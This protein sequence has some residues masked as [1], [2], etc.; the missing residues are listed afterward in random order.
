MREGLLCVCVYVCVCMY[1]CVCVC[2][3]VSVF[4]HVCA[5]V[6]RQSI[7]TYFQVPVDNVVLVKEPDGQGD[8]GAV[9]ARPLLPE[10][11]CLG[12][13]V[14]QLPSGDVLHHKA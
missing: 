14:E 9:E 7:L 5:C 8:L 10:A 2:M 3:Y 13:V 6:N 1:V 12:E 4:V 11:P